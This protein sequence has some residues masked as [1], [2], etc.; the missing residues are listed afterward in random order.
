[1]NRKIRV[2]H[3]D[4]IEDVKILVELAFYQDS[5]HLE[6]LSDYNFRRGI[7]VVW[8]VEVRLETLID[9]FFVYDFPQGC[10]GNKAARATG[11]FELL[12]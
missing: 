5:K 7:E 9:R 6:C 2:D 1:M 11:C 8:V 4:R 12:T 10:N 3:T